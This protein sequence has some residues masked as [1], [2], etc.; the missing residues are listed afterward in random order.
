[1]VTAAQFVSHVLPLDR[2]DEAFRLF[3][4]GET[5]KVLVAVG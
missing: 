4:S 2:L 1:K 5:R 3:V